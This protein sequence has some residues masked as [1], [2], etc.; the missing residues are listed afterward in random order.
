MFDCFARKLQAA[1]ESNGESDAVAADKIGK[2]AT[3]GKKRIF[4][5][6]SEA[7]GSEGAQSEASI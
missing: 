5:D 1:P 6:G 3:V 4:E 7:G 2:P